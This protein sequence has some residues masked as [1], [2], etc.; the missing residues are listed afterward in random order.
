MFPKEVTTTPAP[1]TFLFHRQKV[2]LVSLPLEFE[3]DPELLLTNKIR[4]T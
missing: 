4:W 2:E 3:L 1:M